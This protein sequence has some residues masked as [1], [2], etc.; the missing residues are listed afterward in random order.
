MRKLIQVLI[1]AA[2]LY[3][4]ACAALFLLQDSLL[5]FPRGVSERP[6]QANIEAVDILVDGVRLAGWVVNPTSAGP[7]VVYFGGN[8]E[9]LSRMTHLVARFE[10]TTVMVNYRGYGD[11]EGSP[12]QDALYADA[13]AV[14]DFAQARFAGRPLILFGRSLGT[15]VAVHTA[16]QRTAAGVILMSPYRSIVS[17]AQGLYPIFPVRWLLRH[18]FEAWRWADALPQATLVVI[19]DNDQVVPTHES[20]AFLDHLATSPDVVRHDGGHNVGM[21]DMRIWPHLRK[22]IESAPAFAPPP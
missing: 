9:E 6:D 21:T 10:A 14:V 20:E 13:V 2:V 1:G 18:P 3:A 5:F 19:A 17:V 8:A 7:L 15:G 11:S 16:A 4:A 12:T 22:F